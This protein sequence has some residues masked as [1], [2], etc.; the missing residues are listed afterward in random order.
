MQ[1]RRGRAPPI[2]FFSGEDQTIT[3][4]DW[5]PSL[6]CA[7]NWNEWSLEE[8]L[9]QLPRYLKGRALQEWRLLRQPEEQDYPKTID[10]LH[11]RLDLGSK[12]M[13]MHEFRHSVQRTGEGVQ[14]YIRRLGKTYR[15]AYGQDDL[16]PT[17]QDALL[18]RQL[19]EGL[20]YE[21]VQS[22]AVSGA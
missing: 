13:A 12:T 20:Y 21:L 14:D 16:I 1:P 10:A 11:S 6:E 7:S 3:I 15:V 18:Y 2:E 8:K 9:L 5:L 4:D 22:P 19:Y 17:I